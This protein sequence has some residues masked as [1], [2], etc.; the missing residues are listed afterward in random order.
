MIIFSILAFAFA[1]VITFVAACMAISRNT[2]VSLASLVPAFIACMPMVGVYF[3]QSGD[4]LT[5][6]PLVVVGTILAF[7][8][9]ADFYLAIPPKVIDA[10]TGGGAIV[11]AASVTGTPAVQPAGVPQRHWAAG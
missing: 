8:Q 1:A 10:P 5:L 9:I 11:N 3:D 6:W 4:L 7:R 2:L